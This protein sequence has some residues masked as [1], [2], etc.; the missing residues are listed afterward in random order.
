[1]I[2]T[3]L[4]KKE[5]KHKEGREKHTFCR[6]SLLCKT[7]FCRNL[8][9]PTSCPQAWRMEIHEGSSPNSTAEGKEKRTSCIIP[10]RHAWV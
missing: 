1:M 4:K 8:V 2:N 9:Y 10:Q 6:E 5:T 7:Q 3:T